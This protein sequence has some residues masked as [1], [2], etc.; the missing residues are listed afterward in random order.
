MISYGTEPTLKDLLQRTPQGREILKHLAGAWQTRPELLGAFLPG[1]MKPLKKIGRVTSKI[2]GGLAKIAAG[3]FGIPPSAINALAHIDPT[4]HAALMNKIADAKGIKLPTVPGGTLP[5]A[6][7][8][9][10]KIKPLYIAIG[11]GA[12]VIIGALFFSKKRR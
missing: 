4:T 2:T 10:K 7:E 9:T 8:E 11:A 5:Q 6:P 1:L 3:A 12:L